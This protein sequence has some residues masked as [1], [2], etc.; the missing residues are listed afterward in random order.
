MLQGRNTN[1]AI[2]L[3]EL[4]VGYDNNPVSVVVTISSQYRNEPCLLPDGDGQPPLLYMYNNLKRKWYFCHLIKITH[5]FLKQAWKLD[6]LILG[7]TQ[8]LLSAITL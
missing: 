1:F 4:L 6:T 5:T 2:S 7:Y 8:L 3:R